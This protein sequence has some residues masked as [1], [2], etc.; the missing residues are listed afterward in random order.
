MIFQLHSGH[1]MLFFCQ[2]PDGMFGMIV[3]YL[4]TQLHLSLPVALVSL[5]RVLR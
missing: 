2:K 3:C 5:G 1:T 4:G